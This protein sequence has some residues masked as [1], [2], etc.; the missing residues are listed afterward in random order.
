MKPNDASNL[1]DN[2]DIVVIIDK[3]KFPDNIRKILE[4]NL[5]KESQEQLKLSQEK[6]DK[7]NRLFAIQMGEVVGN[8]Y[9]D[10]KENELEIKKKNDI[11]K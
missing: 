3:E 4:E 10:K 11:Q 9:K 5:P 8:I 1:P 2:T 6:P 7:D